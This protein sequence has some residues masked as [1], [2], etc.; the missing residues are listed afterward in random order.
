MK[1]SLLSLMLA[2][3]VISVSHAQAGAWCSETVEDIIIHKNGNVYFTTNKTCSD[4]WCSLAGDEANKNR[5]LTTM[6]TA[7]TAEHEITFHWRGIDSCNENNASY[8][9]PEYFTLN[10]GK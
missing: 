1:K 6:L 8:A 9:T 4:H 3:S 5:G 7:Q 2:A 10:L